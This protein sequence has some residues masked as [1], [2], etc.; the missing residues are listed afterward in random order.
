MNNFPQIWLTDICNALNGIGLE[1]PDYLGKGKWLPEKFENNF[2][3]I[4]DHITY[5]ASIYSFLNSKELIN[6]GYC[7]ITGE[8]IGT[9]YFYQT[10]G[11]KVYLS[12]RGKQFAEEF[13]RKAHI[14]KF[15]KKPIQ[16]YKESNDSFNMFLF[17]G[18]VIL[19][20]FLIKGCL[21]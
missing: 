7:P 14:K 10:F 9:T 17:T 5:S 8:K 21:S 15:G 18:L 11:R 20:I 1:M 12:L 4:E 2:Q 13:R 3:I 6:R 19:V 16:K